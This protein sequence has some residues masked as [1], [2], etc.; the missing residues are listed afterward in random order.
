MGDDSGALQ[1]I[2]EKEKQEAARI[3]VNLLLISWIVLA[4]VLI[5]EIYWANTLPAII[6]AL[7]GLFLVIPYGLI[8]RGNLTA[9]GLIIVLFILSVIT[10]LAT[11]GKGIHD[12]AAIAFPLV[13]IFA[14]LALNRLGVRIG[15]L[16]ALI[17]IA[18]LVLG[19]ATGV[20]TAKP[21]D[22]ADWMDFVIVSS[23]LFATGLIV[24]ILVRNI[25]RNLEKARE[26]LRQRKEIEEALSRK[27]EET[28]RYF[29]TSL[30]LLCI[31]DSDG[32][33]RRLNPQW[34]KTLGYPLEEL[35]GTRFMNYIHP[36]DIEATQMAVNRLQI[37]EPVIN[38]ENRYRHKDGTYRWIEW[39]SAP[40]DNLIYAAARDVT[41]RKQMEDKLRYQGTHDILTGIYNR[42]FFEV[43]MSRLEGGREYPISILITDIDG[44]KMVNDS[45]GHAAGDQ[46]LK[47][48]AEIL[49][50]V[51]RSEDILA[52]IGGDEFAVLMPGTDE[53]AAQKKMECIRTKLVRHNAISSN[54][55][56]EMS[57]GAATAVKGDLAGTF[58]LADQRMYRD[59]AQRAE[60]KTA[61][62]G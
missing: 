52:R 17:C 21:Y 59:K 3:Q 26:E 16:L 25:R 15:M 56:V 5:A 49:K 19:E 42:S 55:R 47:Q 2:D 51:F 13:I 18:W 28:D 41:E 11:F 40:F 31:A 32:K 43:E 30:D 9:S 24:N 61:N 54:M 46:L 62:A 33:F 45:Q 38:F 48:A 8:R 58:T 57:I 37:R 27:I 50:S 10:L 6:T 23:I 34:E 53:A 36:D 7:G 44:M 1:Y 12:I 39:R 60:L 4:I 14:S 22:R 35:V 20:Y 29:N